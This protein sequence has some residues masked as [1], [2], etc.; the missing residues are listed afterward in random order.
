M[1][2]YQ[3]NERNR[4]WRRWAW[5]CSIAKAIMAI[6]KL[7]CISINNGN[8]GSG[9]Q[10]NGSRKYGGVSALALANGVSGRN[11]GV[12]TQRKS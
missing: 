7:S 12:S 5:R 1:Y 6:I 4:S 3:R 8:N 9:W 10:C 2:Q 11:G